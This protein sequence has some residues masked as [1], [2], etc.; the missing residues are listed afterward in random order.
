MLIGLLLGVVSGAICFFLLLM[1]GLNV[2]VVLSCSGAVAIAFFLLGLA[3]AKLASVPK[4][5][6]EAAAVSAAFQ[7][8]ETIT[9]KSK[10]P[11]ELEEQLRQEEERL[12][13]LLEERRPAASSRPAPPPRRS[14]LNKDI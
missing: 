11:Q 14:S 2:P 4:R 1:Q 7:R 10:S 9:L 3:A 12:R 13:R 5:K 6:K 8:P